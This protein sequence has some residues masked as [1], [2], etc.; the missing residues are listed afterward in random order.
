MSPI[1]R[2]LPGSTRQGVAKRILR[3][4]ILGFQ[5]RG[6]KIVAGR[7]HWKKQNQQASQ[8]HQEATRLPTVVLYPTA[9]P[10]QPKGGDRQE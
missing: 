4:R 3:G 6:S 10:P 2:R 1:L 7:N 9:F 8:Y 5:A